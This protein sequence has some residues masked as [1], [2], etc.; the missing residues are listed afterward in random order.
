MEYVGTTKVL[1]LRYSIGDPDL[2]SLS[3]MF[4]ESP[5]CGYP[6]TVTVQNL[7]AFATHNEMSADFTIAQ[8]G[9]LN[10]IGEYTVTLRSLIQIPDDY[11]K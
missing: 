7:P 4:D 8:N 10:L 9:D 5:I 6:E 3:Y 11:T 2:T 1:E